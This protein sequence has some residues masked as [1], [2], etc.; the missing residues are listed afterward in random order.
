MRFTSFHGKPLK[1]HSQ[2]KSISLL[3]TFMSIRI[4]TMRKNC[5][6]VLL[7]IAVFLQGLSATTQKTYPVDSPIYETIS[8]IYL[9]TG[10]AMPSSSGPWSG[11]ELL[12]M[13]RKIPEESV[14]GILKESYLAVLDELGGTLPVRLGEISMRFSADA[15]LEL[16][17][18]TNTD[19]HT[20]TDLNEVT[21]KSFVGRDNWAYDLVH[22][23]PVFQFNWETDVS[24]FFYFTIEAPLKSGFHNGTGYE[25]EI[26][27]SAFGSN[28]PGLQN[29]PVNGDFSLS[30][31]ANWPYRAFGSFGGK[32]WNVQIGRDRISWGLGKTGNLGI[33]DNLPYHDMMKLSA[34][35]GSF[36]YTFLISSFPHKEN[37]YDPTGYQGS[38][39]KGLIEKSPIS[40]ISL[41]L[42]HR[43]EGRVLRD[44]LAFSITEAIM[45]A[46]ASVTLD[47][48]I[49]NP[50]TV[51][52]NF[53]NPSNA[54]STMVIELDW[55]PVNG[56]NLYGQF[57]LDDFAIPGGE[58]VAGPASEGYPNGLGYLAGARYAT[59]AG[60][61]LLTI[62]LEGVLIDPYTY[63]RYCINPNNAFSEAYGLDYVVP[64]RTYVTGSGKDS[65]VY[66][67]YFLGYRYGGDCI[68]SNFNIEWKKPGK[69]TL[70]SNVFFMAHG[71]HDKW[72]RWD[73]IGG[74]GEKNWN[75]TS[76]T[77][78]TEHETGNYRYD[79]SARNAVS[80]TLDIGA[81]F[82]Y[83]MDNG[84]RLFCQADFIRIWNSFNIAGQDEY[85]FQFVSGIKYTL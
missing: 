73:Q 67:E 72:T 51:F 22:S 5:L 9:L 65:L 30:L 1:T 49:F 57:L 24:D 60:N 42:A 76:V 45:Y 3:K 84:L 4:R 17:A 37:Y 46:S 44:R 75:D 79:V 61:G 2:S 62:N 47:F 6:L 53:Y 28:I 16:Y 54:N 23:D 21:E 70:S 83:V 81:G 13:I 58:D 36:K 27:N 20:R 15:A 10:H 63:L 18:H 78:T 52:H 19:G 39:K 43:I 34:F 50:A 40:G 64:V 71:T 14:P 25:N 7:V 32:S 8:D 80:Y 66:D 56:L 38:D 85:D 41:Y 55:T 77:P 74:N 48:R 31:D 59:S 26:G 12:E 69:I 68:V 11:A 35:S 82:S 33:S 29:I